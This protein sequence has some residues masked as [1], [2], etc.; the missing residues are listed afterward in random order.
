MNLMWKDVL[1][2]HAECGGFHAQIGL[3]GQIYADRLWQDVPM[4]NQW[5]IMSGKEN[6]RNAPWTAKHEDDVI[7]AYFHYYTSHFDQPVLREAFAQIPNILALD[8]HDM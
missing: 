4:L 1:Q 2:K 8:D 5:T 3:G 6:R 7:H